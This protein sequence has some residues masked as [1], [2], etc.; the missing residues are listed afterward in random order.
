VDVDL[1]LQKNFLF[2]ESTRLQFRADFL[3]AFNHPNFAAPN[4]YYSQTATTF[5]N[6]TGSQDPRNLWMFALKFYF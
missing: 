3:N 6:I 5:G 4:M 1:S 2:G